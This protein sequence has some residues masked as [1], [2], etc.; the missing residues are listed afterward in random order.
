MVSS[1]LEGRIKEKMHILYAARLFL[2]VLVLPKKN[3]SQP[4]GALGRPGKHNVYVIKKGADSHWSGGLL[5]R[6][7]VWIF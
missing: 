6:T 1:L 7:E 3:S 4:Q 5:A 2:L